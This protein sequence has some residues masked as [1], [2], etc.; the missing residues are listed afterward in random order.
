MVS[1]QCPGVICVTTDQSCANI[2]ILTS[3]Y[4]RWKQFFV[5]SESMLIGTVLNLM[6]EGTVIY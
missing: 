4:Q 6:F 5:N 3:P 2:N 1:N